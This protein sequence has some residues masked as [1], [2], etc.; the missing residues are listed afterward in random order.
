CSSV[1]RERFICPSP[2][3]NGLYQILE[4]VQGLRSP[5]MGVAV[6]NEVQ[7]QQRAQMKT[8]DFNNEF[9][10]DIPN[11]MMSSA[12]FL[13]RLELRELPRSFV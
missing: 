6:Q 13:K 1:N 3:R 11:R 2:D 9:C 8:I 10:F 4:E 7:N 5:Y 12:P